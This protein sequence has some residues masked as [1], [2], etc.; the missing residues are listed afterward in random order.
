MTENILI[1]QK[2][3]NPWHFVWISIIISELFTAFFNTV[4]SFLVRENI[5]S[6]INNRHIQCCVC[7][8]DRCAYC[9]LF[10]KADR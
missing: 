3:F 7:P 1:K 6:I 4:Q 10:Y 9:Y 2:L 8:S 5:S